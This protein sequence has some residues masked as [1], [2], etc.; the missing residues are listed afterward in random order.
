M[1]PVAPVSSMIM[2]SIVMSVVV[3]EV[4]WDEKRRP[5]L[6]NLT[7]RQSYNLPKRTRSVQQPG[8]HIDEG[9]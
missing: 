9:L 6:F 8:Y 4:R 1:N 7:A 3:D 5:Q 2:V